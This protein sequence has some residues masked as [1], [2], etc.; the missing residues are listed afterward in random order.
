M[1]M[2][3]DLEERT[4]R[5]KKLRTDSATGTSTMENTGVLGFNPNWYIKEKKAKA[6]NRSGACEAQGRV[7]R[8]RL[9]AAYSV[10]GAQVIAH[11]GMTQEQEQKKERHQIQAR[12]GVLDP[13]RRRQ[14]Q[15]SADTTGTSTR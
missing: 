15:R 3:L 14:H 10:T 4:T 13:A 5:K 2:D 12:G 9:V 6:A 8:R 7:G 11:A 1:V